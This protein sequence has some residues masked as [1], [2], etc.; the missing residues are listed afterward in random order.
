MSEEGADQKNV[1]LAQPQRRKCPPCDQ[2][3]IRHF[4]E[5]RRE[6]RRCSNGSKLAAVP[7][8]TSPFRQ[9]QPLC[10]EYLFVGK[11]RTCGCS[12]PWGACGSIPAAVSV[13]RAGDDGPP[14]L[15]VLRQVPGGEEPA[16]RVDET[17]CD[18]GAAR[19]GPDPC[20]RAAEEARTMMP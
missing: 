14:D 3:E 2:M 1:N 15:G 12:G 4:A 10:P 5:R 8:G 17:R 6:D 19:G 7:H 13:M 11:I 16:D 9:A 18:R 20:A